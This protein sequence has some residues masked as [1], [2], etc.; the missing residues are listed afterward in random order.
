MIFAGH[1]EGIAS[2]MLT[3]QNSHFLARGTF[4]GAV[5]HELPLHFDH[6]KDR[7]IGICCPR[8]TASGDIEIEGTFFLDDT[9]Q[10]DAH[11][12]GLLKASMIRGLS[13][14]FEIDDCEQT[15]LFGPQWIRRGSLLEVSLCLI[16]GNRNAR[17]RTISFWPAS[18]E[19]HRK[20][21]ERRQR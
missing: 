19:E 13:I 4:T 9:Q 21:Y 10:R 20:F 14:S 12:L 16:G 8:Q 5:P 2:T 3:L 11:I 18:P 1:V 6:L 7:A 17:I 15:S